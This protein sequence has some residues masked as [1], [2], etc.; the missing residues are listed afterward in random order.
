MKVSIIGGG[1]LVGSMTAYALQCGGVVSSICLI[2]ANKDQAQ[3]QALDL[4]H[5]ASLVAENLPICSGHAFLS[6]VMD[7]FVERPVEYLHAGS[8]G[9]NQLSGDEWSMA[10]DSALWAAESF[11]CRRTRI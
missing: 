11:I 8:R 10:S 2:D 9:G 3:G 1:G 5:G 7:A 4:L 6:F